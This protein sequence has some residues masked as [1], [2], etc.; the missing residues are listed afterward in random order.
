MTDVELVSILR[1]TCHLVDLKYFLLFITF[2][3][4]IEILLGIYC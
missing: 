4:H 1:G 3:I 2:T